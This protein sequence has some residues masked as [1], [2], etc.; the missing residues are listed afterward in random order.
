MEEKKVERKTGLIREFFDFLKEYKI[1]GLAVA[2][3]MGLAAN[4]LMRSLV[5]NV[6]MV[7]ITP[8]IPNDK[9]EDAVFGIGQIQIRWGL[10]LG[11]L[12]Y[13]IVIAFVVFFVAKFFLKEEKVTK[14]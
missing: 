14:K 13:F 1:I 9:W 12:I 8:L 7:L 4:Q 6:I 2:F 3:I 11:D 10:F 5:D